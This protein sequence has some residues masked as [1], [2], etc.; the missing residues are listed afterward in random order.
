MG[1]DK[2]TGLTMDIGQV[3]R[4]AIVTR[5][6][7]RDG[8]QPSGELARELC[9][10]FAGK[11]TQWLK[12]QEVDRSIAELYQ[13]W[14]DVLTWV[15]S[16][17]GF[18]IC[19][20][21]L[22]EPPA[23]CVYPEELVGDAVT[24]ITLPLFRRFYYDLALAL[25]CGQDSG[26]S[27]HGSGV[28]DTR[29]RERMMLFFGDEGGVAAP[30]ENQSIGYG[31][32]GVSLAAFSLLCSVHTVL[33]LAGAVGSGRGRRA[34]EFFLRECQDRL[35]HAV[36]AAVDDDSLL[37]SRQYEALVSMSAP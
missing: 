5:G 28:C 11:Q 25:P 17:A 21:L 27:D 18:L 7:A 32:R 4:G 2:G 16:R 34:A 13:N 20:V 23:C 19:D 37:R 26:E 9:S 35:L 3:Y 15:K 1:E 29:L 8:L 33:F 31:L 24:P 6:V 10:F 30:L 14:C 12:A 22:R 36:N